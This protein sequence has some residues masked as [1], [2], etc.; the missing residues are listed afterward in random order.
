[1]EKND[2]KLAQIGFQIGP[3]VVLD[4]AWSLQGY[5]AHKKTPN[6]QEGHAALDRGLL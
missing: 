3:G 4:R 5:L 6:P 2:R 1:M